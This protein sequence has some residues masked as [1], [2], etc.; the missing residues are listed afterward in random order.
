LPH[1]AYFSQK[2]DPVT[3]FYYDASMTPVEA[4]LQLKIISPDDENTLVSAHA[5]IVKRAK[6]GYVL[7]RSLDDVRDMA[8]RGAAAYFNPQ[9]EVVV[10]GGIT[11]EYH[12]DDDTTKPLIGAEYG[13]MV[14][15]S[16]YERNGFSGDITQ[17][18]AEVYLDNFERQSDRDPNFLLFAMAEVEGPGNG[19]FRRLNAP[20]IADETLPQGAFAEGG[21][22]KYFNYGLNGLR[23]ER[24]N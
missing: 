7:N 20:Q 9:G 1:F 11:H 14:T 23:R 19:V 10:F 6:E 16:G 24:P 5:L 3:S 17:R 4:G 12:Q 22:K 15:A 2:F 13:A 18:V 21:D 8:I